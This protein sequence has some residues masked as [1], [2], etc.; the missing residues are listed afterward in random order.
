MKTILTPVDFSGITPA[1]VAAAAQLAKDQQ[2]K[3]VLMNVAQ[4]PIVTSQYAPFLE[5]IGE[6]IAV[7]ERAAAKELSRLQES[8]A[9]SGVA[10]ETIQFAGPPVTEILKQADLLKADYI[11]LG[12][13]GH[14]AFY[15]LLVGSTTHGIL[16]RA[17]CPV[18][19]VPANKVPAP[20]K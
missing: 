1:V 19:I 18:L 3:V 8:L 16:L 15:D 12:S 14:T 4:Q 20:A 9:A 7:S 6:I 2:G 11:V 5:N 13:H 10:T 17:K